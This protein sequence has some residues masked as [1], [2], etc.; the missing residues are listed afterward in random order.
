MHRDTRNLYFELDGARKALRTRIGREDSATK[1][2]D[3]ARTCEVSPELLARKVR[4]D[5]IRTTGSTNHALDECEVARVDRLNRERRAGW[6]RLRE[7]GIC[8][9]QPRGRRGYEVVN[10]NVSRLIQLAQTLSLQGQNA[11]FD[12]VAWA[13]DGAGQRRF[14]ESLE[15]ELSRW[16]TLPD[17][18]SRRAAQLLLRLLAYM[19]KAF[20][21]GRAMSL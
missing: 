15:C 9:V 17:Q 5:C 8:R 10:W 13:C 18:Q 11:L 2:R 7:T 21:R 12:E 6:R 19:P 14:K 4:Q 16:R 20:T 1:L 3:V